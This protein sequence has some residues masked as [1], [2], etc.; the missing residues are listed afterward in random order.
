MMTDTKNKGSIA[1][2]KTGYFVFFGAAIGAV[3]GL[4][5]YVE[6]WL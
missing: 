4:V 5:A 6:G 3:L 1:A 2:I